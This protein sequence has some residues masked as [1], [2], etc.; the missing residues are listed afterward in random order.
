MN[1]I[2]IYIVSF[3]LVLAL[4]SC[5]TNKVNVEGINSKYNGVITLLVSISSNNVTEDFVCHNEINSNTLSGISCQNNKSITYFSAGFNK[6]N[7]EIEITNKI[8]YKTYPATIID[9]II[10]TLFDKYLI[11]NNSYTMIN[12]TNKQTTIHKNNKRITIT[13]L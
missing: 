12:K 8:L 13:Q 1:I 5:S 9:S 10:I 11:K 7:I 4:V 6:Q 2:K 3:L